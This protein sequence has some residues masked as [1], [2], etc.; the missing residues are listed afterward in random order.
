MENMLK[1]YCNTTLS[2]IACNEFNV[3]LRGGEMFNFKVHPKIL[4]HKIHSLITDK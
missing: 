4:K 2:I 3:L 1:L